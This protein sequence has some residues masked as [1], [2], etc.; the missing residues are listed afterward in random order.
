M[1]D[2]VPPP[3][4]RRTTRGAAVLTAAGLAL[5]GS[6]AVTAPSGAATAAP[7][8][9]ALVGTASA[10]STEQDLDW[11]AP[12]FVNDGDASTRWS[13]SYDDA[14]WVQVELAEP[15][16][17]DHVTIS[18]P[19]ACAADYVVQT[20]T[21]GTTWTDRERVTI[22]TCWRTDVVQLGVTE[23]V[24]FVRMQGID[25]ASQWGYSIYVLL[26][27]S[28]QGFFLGEHGWFD[29]RFMYDESIRMPLLVSYPRAIPAGRVVPQLVTNVDFARTILDAAGVPPV[30]GMQGVSFWPQLTTDPD[31]PTQDAVYYRYYENDDYWHHTLAHYGIRT[32]RYKLIY[33]YND[34]M[35]LPGTSGVT[36]PPEWELYDLQEDPQE[37][38]N[39]YLDP[40]YAQVR[41]ELTQRLHALQAELGDAPHPSDV[42]A[43]AVAA[44]V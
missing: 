9:L 31:A 34:G 18:W 7:E 38:R 13:S 37:L 20:S 3:A 1:R 5:A 21:D 40:A 41:A 19:G 6:L 26:Y 30:A 25:R 24:R 27:T 2:H 43:R 33:F 8:N 36:Y 12:R 44:T 10:S 17:V 35:G 29:K 32:E 14:N 39:V 28:D 4:R 15:S 23:P 22:A 11:L 16:P 42:A